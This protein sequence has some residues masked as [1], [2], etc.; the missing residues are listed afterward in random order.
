[1]KMNLH[2]FRELCKDSIISICPTQSIP[3]RHVPTGMVTYPLF[4]VKFM[5]LPEKTMYCSE[6]ENNRKF[7]IEFNCLFYG[8]D[9]FG[10]SK[11][12]ILKL[13]SISL[14]KDIKRVNDDLFRIY[15][16]KFLS[17]LKWGNE[18]NQHD[19]F[20]IIFTMPFEDSR[21]FDDNK[22]LAELILDNPF[23]AK[24]V[25]KHEE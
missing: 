15:K 22:F 17:E 7:D 19:Y 23:Y 10:T 25:A 4:D 18:N 11:I 5:N 1:M 3:R 6:I 9:D 8:D 24:S 21:E 14:K 12:G 13:N 20:Q 2:V 16:L